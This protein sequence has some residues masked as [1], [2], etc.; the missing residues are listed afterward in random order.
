[1]CL[2]L[3]QSWLP[4]DRLVYRMV[5]MWWTKQHCLYLTCLPGLINSYGLTCLS[6][7]R[8]KVSRCE[9]KSTHSK[10]KKKTLHNGAK[11]VHCFL[12]IGLCRALWLHWVQVKAWQVGPPIKMVDC[13][14]DTFPVISTA[15]LC[16]AAGIVS[17]RPGAL[18]L[19]RNTT[20]LNNQ[21]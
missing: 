20:F 2:R 1:M 21:S 3:G 10:K 14:N 6:M 7:W 13:W 5:Y 15:D 16:S 9:N 17:V 4:G 19:Y 12:S 8:L 18:I 11:L